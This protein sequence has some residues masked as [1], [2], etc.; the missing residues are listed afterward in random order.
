[1]GKNIYLCGVEILK[2]RSLMQLNYVYRKYDDYYVGN[3]IDFPEYDTQG[4]TI[5]ELEEMLKSLYA[6]LMTFEDIHSS[7]PYQRGVLELT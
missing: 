7:V 5:D 6:D 1:L 3:L 4:K 2:R